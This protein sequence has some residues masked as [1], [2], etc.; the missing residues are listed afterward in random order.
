M[1]K[2][3]ISLKTI[4]REQMQKAVDKTPPSGKHRGVVAIA[5]VATLGSLLFGYDTGVIS[6]ALPYMYM[7]DGASGLALTSLE[8][9]GI[10]GVLLIGAAVGAL[11]GGLLSDKYGRRHNITLL[12]ILFF[13]GAC[14]NAFSPNVWIMYIFR[15]ILGFAVGGASAT[16]PVYLAETAPKRIRG[17]I[18][19]LDQLMIVTGQLLAFTINAIINSMSGGPKLTITA[20]P[21]GTLDPS[22]LGHDISFDVLSK[23]QTS[24]G[25]NLEPAA[26]HAFLEQ[27][28]VS[29]GNGD[30]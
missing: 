9:G 8:E 12:A 24:Q 2:G 11:I 10:S 30:T 23:M 22:L 20:D 17:S 3:D 21:S 25:G 7:P 19:A 18:V 15:F 26:Y 4:N 1:S 14:G 28:Q 13:F 16:V 5:A 6:G 29:A 27:L